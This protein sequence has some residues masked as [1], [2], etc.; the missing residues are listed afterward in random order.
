MRYTVNE[1]HS[2]CRLVQFLRNLDSAFEGQSP[3]AST[4]L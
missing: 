3:V 1:V 2:V 4:I